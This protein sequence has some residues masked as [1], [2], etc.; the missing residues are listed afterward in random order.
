[1]TFNNNLEN[2]VGKM[3]GFRQSQAGINKIL[4]TIETIELDYHQFQVVHPAL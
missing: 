3:C 1:M 2:P 4:I